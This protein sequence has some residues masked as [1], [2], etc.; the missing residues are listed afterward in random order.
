M[1]RTSKTPLTL[2]IDANNLICRMYYGTFGSR[3]GATARAVRAKVQQL[4]ELYQPE[5]VLAGID[6]SDSFREDLYGNYKVKG[7]SR[8]KPEELKRLLR[9]A[10]D[11]MHAA[12]AVPVT[13][14]HNEAD[15]V[16]ATLA[17]RAPGQVVI[18]TADQ[19]L[20]GLVD[21][22]VQVFDLKDRRL[23]DVKT[24][25]EK[26]GVP[27]HLLPFYKALVGD[28]ADRVPGVPFLEAAQ[29]AELVN[30]YQTPERLFEALP[31][32][33]PAL[34]RSFRRSSLERIKLH[35]KLHTLNDQAP[36]VL[37]Q[38]RKED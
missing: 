8:Q 38:S 10:P 3:E 22:N 7:K 36:N 20:Y 26:C 16:L 30:T 17:R 18:V 33:S 28:V 1:S 2:L 27:P 5:Y 4:V 15:D 24:A 12:G 37:A 35:I 6:D 19:D 14:E 13:A 29:A 9:E 23:V 31:S 21:D 25:Q 32:L 11:L 34:Q